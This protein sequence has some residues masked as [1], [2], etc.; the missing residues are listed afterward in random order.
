MSIERF[1]KFANLL[2]PVFLNYVQ[3][4]ITCILYI[5]KY[6]LCFVFSTLVKDLLIQIREITP[7]PP[8]VLFYF[9]LKIILSSCVK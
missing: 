6:N 2:N 7:E 4:A 8:F 3:I 1:L 9:E 5:L